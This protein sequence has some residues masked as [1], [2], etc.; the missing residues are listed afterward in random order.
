MFKYKI[1]NNI[2]QEGIKVL[3]HNKFIHDEE[4]PHALIL[5]S[6]SYQAKI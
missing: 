1:F 4:E 5:R 2:A 6:K 3:D